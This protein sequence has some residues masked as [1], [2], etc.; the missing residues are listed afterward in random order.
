MQLRSDARANRAR[1]LETAIDTFAE[2]GLHTE[3]RT[4]AERAGVAIGTL[5]HHYQSKDDLLLAIIRDAIHSS[6]NGAKQ[7]EAEPDGLAAL[8]RLLVA[9]F[10]AAERYGWIAE[11]M[12]TGQLPAACNAVLESETAEAQYAPRFERLIRRCIEQGTLRPDL[13]VVLAASLL[14]GVTLP[15]VYRRRLR[16]QGPEAAASA[17]VDLVLTGAA[18]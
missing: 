6:V 3:M 9:G 15:W 4:I 17:V 13:E 5:Y 8:R 7:A 16:E 10:A 18:P 11:A 1:I 12:L 2:Q 14:Q